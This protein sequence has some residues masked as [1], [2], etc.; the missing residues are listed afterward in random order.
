MSYYKKDDTVYGVYKGATETTNLEEESLSS[1]GEDSVEVIDTKNN[2]NCTGVYQIPIG[3]IKKGKKLGNGAFGIVYKGTWRD[4]PVAMKTIS[5][6]TVNAKLSFNVSDI[7]QSIEWEISRISSV[8]NPGVVQF[9]GIYKE[10]D[11]SF[12][13]IMEYCSNGTLQSY[14]KKNNVSWDQRIQW[15][16]EIAEGLNYLHKQGIIHRDLKAENILLTKSY[17]A[18]LA[19]LGVA[20][21]D[22]LLE[23]NQATV[24]SSG[25][26]DMRFVAPEVLIY[27]QSCSLKTDIYAFGLV[28]W[29]IATDG[30]DPPK[31]LNS[32]EFFDDREQ[33]L[34]LIPEISLEFAMVIN[35]CVKVH[36]EERFQIGQVLNNLLIL[37][38]LK[39]LNICRKIESICYS[40][41]LEGLSFIPPYVSKNY[42]TYPDEYWKK[43]EFFQSI[44]QSPSNEQLYFEKYY[45]PE[46]LEKFEWTNHLQQNPPISLDKVLFDF[47]DSDNTTVAL[48]GDA[49]TGKSLST[50][51][52][53]FNIIQDWK[54]LLSKNDTSLLKDKYFPIFIR[55][56]LEH[57]TQKDL[58]NSF[59]HSLKYYELENL[60]D[61]M[62]FLIIVDGYD[63]CLAN[64]NENFNIGDSLN[65]PKNIKV[66]LLITC[67]PNTISNVKKS[68]E[69]RNN[70][71]TYNF[72]PFNII[73]LLKYLQNHKN[74]TNE[75]FS[76]YKE[77]MQQFD[78]LRIVL[79]NPF[80]LKLVTECWDEVIKPVKNFNLINRFVIYNGYIKNWLKS[81]IVLLSDE[82][83]NELK[84]ESSSIFRS[85]HCWASNIAI[86]SFFER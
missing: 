30:N 27:K 62:N 55:P 41:Y 7:N 10:R 37:T 1:G 66:K 76:Y 39:L 82:I 19:D 85:F 67:R 33:K 56:T 60:F 50:H 22:P 75:E 49:G 45:F 70:L 86:E 79:R 63:E 42:V 74:W 58:E 61:N 2:I 24:V 84:S 6:S 68:F 12:F 83:R 77:K 5:L 53:A 51:L 81:K 15:S 35:G 47:L 57:W 18:K 65:I 25:L 73:Q 54:L 20:Q 16:L 78:Q 3:S 69:F 80:V 52:L 28:C 26:Q 17:S 23:E 34:S 9:Y 71:V 36:P 38:K 44:E 43:L 64:I 72:L 11:E 31:P 14:L 29:Q 59:M 32:I 13:I 40:R 4:I 8:S 21:V 46:R 48:F